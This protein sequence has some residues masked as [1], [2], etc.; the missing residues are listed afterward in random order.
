MRNSLI[1]D[2]TGAERSGETRA[3]F[4]SL[5]VPCVAVY[6]NLSDFAPKQRAQR[7]ARAAVISRNVF[8]FFADERNRMSTCCEPYGGVGGVP[9][10]SNDCAQPSVSGET[11]LIHQTNNSGSLTFFFFLAQRNYFFS[12]RT[13]SPNP[14][15][16]VVAVF[17]CYFNLTTTPATKRSE[18]VTWLWRI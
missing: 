9:E 8:F 3:C 12:P 16:V 6:L 14:V 5:P 2:L 13:K 10:L 18:F 11:R 15:F 4:Y 1:P 17:C 7:S